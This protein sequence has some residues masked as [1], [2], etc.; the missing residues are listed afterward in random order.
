VRIGDF[1]LDGKPDLVTADASYATVSELQGNGDGTFQRAGPFDGGVQNFSVAVGD[2]NGDGKPDLAVANFG[3]NMVSL[4]SGNGDGSFG[5]PVK[6]AVG[7]NPRSIVERDF[8]G[9]GKLDLAV[10]NET[11]S[12]V[13]V[14]LGNGD[15]T[16]QA[17]VNYVAGSNPFYVAV[18]DFNGDGKLDLAVANSSS[19]NLSILLGNGDGTFQPA[20]D[21][22]AGPNPNSVAIADFN[23]D[24]K[25]DLAVAN[26][27]GVNIF[28][29]N[30]DG[31]FQAAVAYAAQIAMTS[32]AIGDFN[33]DGKLDLAAATTGSVAVLLGN[34][35]GTFGPGVDYAAGS[36]PVSLAVGD[37]NNDGRLDMAVA[38]TA[39]AVLLQPGLTGPNATPAP[40]I[41]TFANQNSGTISPAQPVTLSNN[42]TAALSI[43]SIAASKSFSETDNC[44]AN[45]PAASSCTINVSFV[46][47]DGGHLT[48][49]L[50]ITDN[51]PGSPQ[52]VTLEGDA[53]A[54]TLAPPN[55]SF[56]CLIGQCHSQTAKLTNL[57]AT[58]LIIASITIT[59]NKA[60]NGDQGFTQT[61]NCPA[62][63]LMG[64]FC[65]IQVAFSGQA[66]DFQYTGSLNVQD[67]EGLQR[68]SL[69]GFHAQ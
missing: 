28:L 55:M 6:Y 59:S 16:F 3:E 23:G 43:S 9:D 32:M 61:N 46:P 5:T 57:G 1:N 24:G 31:T 52:T 10:A 7:T 56:N 47:A 4:L 17:A 62:T 53:T 29:G 15:L 64:Q 19:G 22:I 34:G 11:D 48:G 8:N 69:H 44:G 21:Y 40:T 45:L 54:V 33:G 66:A 58:P 12:T 18:G 27:H 2:F 41:L 65:S 39:V 68:V 63:L 20:V 13:S 49:T 25:L 35:D 37:F 60:G 30:G 26:D 36:M 14:L 50:S 42:G 38:G 51:A 67:N